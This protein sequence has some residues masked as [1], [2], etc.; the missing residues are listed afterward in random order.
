VD[1]CKE[2]GIRRDIHDKFVKIKHEFVE[3][4]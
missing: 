4:G 1:N 2:C 3:N